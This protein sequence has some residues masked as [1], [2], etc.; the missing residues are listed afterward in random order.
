[1]NSVKRDAVDSIT[2][3]YKLTGCCRRTKPSRA[4]HTHRHTHAY[5]PTACSM[6]KCLVSQAQPIPMH[7]AQHSTATVSCRKRKAMHQQQQAHDPLSSHDP[8]YREIQSITTVRGWCHGELLV[9]QQQFECIVTYT[10]PKPDAVAQGG[11]WQPPHK[12]RTHAPTGCLK[13]TVGAWHVMDPSSAAS[14]R[15]SAGSVSSRPWCR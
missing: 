15:D 11:F 13:L 10:W 1:M 12:G 8:L 7:H 14:R 9:Q 3:M 2:S 4:A 6:F 5:P